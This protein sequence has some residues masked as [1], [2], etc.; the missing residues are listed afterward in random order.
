MLAI[1]TSIIL[2]LTGAIDALA[3]LVLLILSPQTAIASGLLLILIGAG[4]FVMGRMLLT[5]QMKK[6]KLAAPPPSR[7]AMFKSAMANSAFARGKGFQPDPQPAGSIE[8][9]R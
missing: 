8:V 9:R 4:L 5:A 2:Q 6:F 3:G 1:K 7:E